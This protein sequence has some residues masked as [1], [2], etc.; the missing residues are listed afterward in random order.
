MML[1]WVS[2][3]GVPSECGL[4]GFGAL[5]G[6]TINKSPTIHVVDSGGSIPPLQR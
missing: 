5:F 2:V 1:F 3:Y 6:A 4:S